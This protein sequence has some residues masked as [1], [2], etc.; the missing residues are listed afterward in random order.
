MGMDAWTCEPANHKQSGSRIIRYH[1]CLYLA[2]TEIC[3]VAALCLVMFILMVSCHR[4]REQIIFVSL[5]D[6]LNVKITDYLNYLNSR[7]DS[8]L[9]W[10]TEEHLYWIE[11]TVN[12]DPH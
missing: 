2:V 10:K 6:L 9:Y 1:C 7:P 8:K 12:G 11:I 3:L 5:V 4:F